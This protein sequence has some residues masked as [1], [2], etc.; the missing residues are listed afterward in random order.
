MANPKISIIVPNYNGLD[1]LP[2]ALNSLFSQ[3]LREIEVLV[4]DDCSSDRSWAYLEARA[5][6]EPRLRIFRQER[7]QGVSAARNRALAEARGDFIAFCDNDDAYCP[8]ALEKL[9]KLAT[10][11]QVEYVAAQVYT[12]YPE[13]LVDRKD[14][15]SLSPRPTA[16]EALLVLNTGLGGKLLARDLVERVPLR[17]NPAVK[18]QEEQMLTTLGLAHAKGIAI[19]HEPLYVYYHR[20]GSVSNSPRKMDMSHFEKAFQPL[21]AALLAANV[22]PQIVAFL[23]INRWLYG[24]LLNLSKAGFPNAALKAT[25]ARFE[26]QYPKW[27]EN[28]YLHMLGR[29]KVE[30]LAMARRHVW[31]LCRLMAKAHGWILDRRAKRA[32]P[33]ASA[34]TDQVSGEEGDLV[35]AE[36]AQLQEGLLALLDFVDAFCRSEGLRYYGAYGTALGAIR[37]GGFIPWDDDLD[38]CLPRPD[39][40]AFLKR[41]RAR[42]KD[43]YP[44]VLQHFEDDPVCPT[45]YAKIRLAG[46]CLAEHENLGLPIEQGIFIDLFPL[47]ALPLQPRQA[48]AYFRRN[49]RRFQLYV[50]KSIGQV[51]RELKG[52]KDYLALGLRK[53][54]HL[55]LKGY[56]KKRLY[57]KLD[58][59]VRRYEQAFG[60]V[61]FSPFMQY[62]VYSMR[63]ETA[64]RAEEVLP[65]R[66]A[67]FAGRR[68]PLPAAVES[69]LARVY[70]RWQELPPPAER[71]G[72]RPARLDLQALSDPAYRAVLAT[73][74]AELQAKA[75]TR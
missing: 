19:L 31:P 58:R 60:R 74:T 11:A 55:L 69:H 40:E 22:E 5:A 49:R 57:R 47:D 62:D 64:L 33:S 67:D 9:Y 16:E 21:A 14:F 26:Q 23:G 45:Y 70:G 44:F 66:E 7:N 48:K 12:G 54:L 24:E 20:P 36:R 51:H 35:S 37:H 34:Q 46:T 59:A 56:P 18:I 43:F 61:S 68:L 10:E 73:I 53:T 6:N 3:S 2:R 52:P 25:L 17:M 65:L 1:L 32:L 28:A 30:F 41:F 15:T 50:A 4:V 29:A 71:K 75:K 13:G 27:W 38:L 63:P 42:A 39:Y 8:G 72:H